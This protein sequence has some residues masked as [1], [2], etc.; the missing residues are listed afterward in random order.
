MLTDEV[1]KLCVSCHDRGSGDQ[2]EG[3]DD[4]L[5]CHDAHMSNDEYLLK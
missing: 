5:E 3:A 2:H 4:C 1:A